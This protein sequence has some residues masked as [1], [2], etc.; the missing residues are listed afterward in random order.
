MR[1]FVSYQRRDAL[2][3]AHLLG[4]ALRAAGHE[5]FVDTGDIDGGAP[6]REV[7][8]QSIAQ[9]NVVVALVGAGFDAARLHEPANVIAFEWQRAR[10]HG[11]PVVPALVDRP[12]MPADADLPAPLRWFTRANAWPLRSATLG[13]DVDALVAGLPRLAVAP[14]QAARV[15]WV[16]DKPANNEN[17]RA[18]LRPHGLVFDN[19]VSTREALAQMAFAPYDLVITDLGRS[20]S[21]DRS[22]HAGHHFLAEPALRDGG[23]PVVVYGNLAARIRAKGLLAQGAAAVCTTPEDLVRV[24]LALLGRDAGAEAEVGAP[25]VRAPPASPPAAPSRAEPSRRAPGRAG[26]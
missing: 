2:W 14:R 6:F 17:E 16:D 25:A 11:L 21:S 26:R 10:F 15:L 1:V 12:G 9:A 3:P 22:S 5:A 8:A 18:L 24:V 4:Y 20:G 23:P 7:I 19:V 13:P